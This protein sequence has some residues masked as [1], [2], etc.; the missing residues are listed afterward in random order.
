[1]VEE[2]SLEELIEGSE[3]DFSSD[4]SC[5]DSIGDHC[6]NFVIVADST[7]GGLIGWNDQRASGVVFAVVT[8]ATLEYQ[9]RVMQD[10]I[11]SIYRGIVRYR[12]MR[13]LTTSRDA[14]S[15]VP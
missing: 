5:S 8:G 10:V 3:A 13:G 7:L 12:G 2:V 9:V 11:Y 1:M 4:K 6:G 15:T 14:L